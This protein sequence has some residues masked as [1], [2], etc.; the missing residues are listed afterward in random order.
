MII[1]FEGQ[2]TGSKFF[3]VL[4]LSLVSLFAIF[5]NSIFVNNIDASRLYTAR[6]QGTVTEET[7]E[8]GHKRGDTS[9][10]EQVKFFDASS[11]RDARVT[12]H[13]MALDPQYCVK[14]D[15]PN[16]EI[17]ITCESTNLSQV[18]DVLND[19]GVLKK[20]DDGV[21]LL[22]ANL[23]INEGATFTIDSNDT[24]WLK[25]DST[26]NES[27]YQIRV[28]GSMKVDS[29]KISSWNTTSNNYT[30]TDGKIA[31]ASIA[32]VPKGE[33][34]ADIT[35]SELSYL[36]Y[37]AS[38]RQGLTYIKAD[39][40]TLRNNTIHH[41]WYG[42]YSRG[43][44]NMIIADND[45]YA[46]VKYG[47]DPHTGSHDLIIRNNRVHDNEGLGI[48]CSLDCKNIVIEGNEVF[49]NKIGGVML[50]RNVVDSVVANNTVYDEVKG[51]IISESHNDKIY[52]N[53]VSN[54]DVGIEAKSNSSMNRIYN[55]SVLNPSKYGIQ[56]ITGAKE[57]T[58]SKNL[59][60]NPVKYGICVYNGGVK[61]ILVENY[62]TNSSKH[63][64]CIYDEASDNLV[65]A[66]Y[67]NGAKRYGI[68]ITDANVKNN[69]LYGNSIN[70]TKTGISINNNTESNL[71]QN[72][73]SLAEDSAYSITGNSLLKLL[74]TTFH[75]D[76]ISSSGG[77]NNT[78]LIAD[79]GTIIINNGA[80]NGTSIDT[81]KNI[82]AIRLQ[83]P[84]SI[85]VT[86]SR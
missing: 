60:A 39:G 61:N 80:G 79:S 6:E 37:H 72:N 47:L 46:N 63:G 15:S 36:G 25:I 77:E 4:I 13:T 41:L 42:L 22:N 66:N 19:P 57:N 48:V 18:Y 74:N 3:P 73:V 14:Y 28:I 23:T 70:M 32:V 50:S 76:K 35:N 30:T 7:S 67:I 86:T 9:N 17:T 1:C 65:K 62:I 12:V 69:T 49:G 27:A 53:V 38:G 55:N 43:L 82:H 24:K 83:D 26:T 54:S 58:I 56:I 51:I 33:G 31:R 71:V 85:N 2:S 40:G 8:E 59:I 29:V 68:Q 34:K 75:S 44:S 11:S 16:R 81:A 78:L 45:I 5:S 84:D 64:I 52:N 20:E 10:V 21:W